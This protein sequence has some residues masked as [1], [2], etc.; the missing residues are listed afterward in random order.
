MKQEEMI[1]IPM[2]SRRTHL[3]KESR[4]AVGSLISAIRNVGKKDVYTHFS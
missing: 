3:R 4:T 1:K 2:R